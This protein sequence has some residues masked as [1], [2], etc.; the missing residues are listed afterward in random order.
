MVTWIAA[1]LGW[2]S[3]LSAQAPRVAE[4]N[5]YV[6]AAKLRAVAGV[7][8]EPPAVLPFS[9]QKYRPK[10]LPEFAPPRRAT[11]A[12]ARA[13]GAAVTYDL[14]TGE[15]KTEPLTSLR[16][17][18]LLRNFS[19]PS[20]GAAG[21][22]AAELRTPSAFGNLS[23]IANPATFPWQTNCKLFF[24]TANGNFVASGTL[25]HPRYVI[26]A[27]HCVY[28]HD[29][30]AGFA[31]SMTVVPGYDE[32]FAAF[33]AAQAVRFTT[34]VGWSQNRDFNFDLAVV[35]I[36]RPVGA[37]VGWLGYG[38]NSNNSFFS[39]LTMH[40]AGYPAE[41][42]YAG[43]EMYYRFGTFDSIF[44]ELF[45]HNNPSFGGQSGSGSYRIENGTDR[46]VHSV[47]SYHR[48][49]RTIT[50]QPRITE[51]KFN[52]F[53]N[54]A[55]ATT[56]ASPDL[57]MLNTIVSPG[58]VTAGSALGNVSYVIFNNSS[59]TWSGQISYDVYLSMNDFISTS[60][61][62]LQSRSWTGTLAP[63][64]VI[65]LTA[66]TSPPVV[67][68]NVAAGDYYLGGILTVTDSNTNNNR[69]R[70]DDVA[71]L[72]VNVTAP[73]L[74]LGGGTFNLV[75]DNI[76]SLDTST[77]TWSTRVAPRRTKTLLLKIE[78][79]G[80]ANETFYLSAVGDKLGYKVKIK[81]NFGNNI[82]D[83]VLA[84]NSYLL[85]TFAPGE[86]QYFKVKVEGRRTTPRRGFVDYTFSLAPGDQVA[87]DAVR[88][89]VTAR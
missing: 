7:V 22:V 15:T 88:L 55:N 65:R 21:G 38:W 56:P 46:Y 63:N 68:G 27:G 50:G 72:R 12:D 36:E 82:T 13:D 29:N 9:P 84:G 39:G 49:N 31:D 3:L 83:D 74:A 23:L 57:Q 24:T 32:G 59:T 86:V 8:E 87:R 35:E 28:D 51:A 58:A 60:D 5:A 17:A 85:G 40:N 89:D 70:S 16:G 19:P 33:G 44:T 81:D 20:A 1:W 18:N 67:P 2:C 25:I 78:N 11:N 75:G 42:P 79:D 37:V 62:Y 47:V 66:T 43:Q 80:S 41:S 6:D 34:F 14:R 26:T 77:Q 45:E 10:P 76:Y 54:A 71:A 73:D 53:V 64:G 48:N 52:V 30:N 61:R 4:T 69:T